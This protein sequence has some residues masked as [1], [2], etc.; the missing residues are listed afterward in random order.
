MRYTIVKLLP[1]HYGLPFYRVRLERFFFFR[2]WLKD[3]H[4]RVLEF[5]TRLDADSHVGRIQQDALLR[6]AM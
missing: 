4:G 1:K 6:M 2:S 3:D 5:E